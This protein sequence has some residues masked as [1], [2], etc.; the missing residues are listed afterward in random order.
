MQRLQAVPP[1]FLLHEACSEC[2]PQ[3]SLTIHNLCFSIVPF[4]ATMGCIRSPVQLQVQ[5]A[6]PLRNLRSMP[7]NTVKKLRC[8]AVNTGRLTNHQLRTIDIFEHLAGYAAASITMSVQQHLLRMTRFFPEGLP[9]IVDV[10]RKCIFVYPVIQIREHGCSVDSDPMEQIVRKYIGIV[11]A[12]LGR[13][14][15]PNTTMLQNLRQRSAI[16]KR[17]REPLNIRGL[18]EFLLVKGLTVQHLPH[19]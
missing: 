5:I 3:F 17:I 4:I 18:P 8:R 1:F 7:G 11:P 2:I 13:H 15:K 10:F 19:Q 12:Q 9:M 14:K 6:S 16:T